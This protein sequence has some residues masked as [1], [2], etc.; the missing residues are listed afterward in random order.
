[1]DSAQRIPK[2]GITVF[3]FCEHEKCQTEQYHYVIAT[4]YTGYTV[5]FN[6]ICYVCLQ[7]HEALVNAHITDEE[8]FDEMD[9]MDI[10][11]W[12]E[13]VRTRYEERL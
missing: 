2:D 13:L 7:R 8:I 3:M 1:M 9:E 5:Y 11:T 10:Y 4:K 12:N 6:K